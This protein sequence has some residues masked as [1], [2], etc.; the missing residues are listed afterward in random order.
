MSS[1]RPPMTAGSAALLAALTILGFLGNYYSVPLFFGA[2]F[3]FGSIAVLL[4]LYFYGLTYGLIVAIIVNIYCFFLWGHPYGSLNFILEA[5][6]VGYLLRSGHKNLFLID[7]AFWLFVGV[8]LVVLEHTVVL[9]MGT[10]ITIFIILKQAI[11]GMFNAL[12]ANLCIAYLPLDKFLGHAPTRRTFSLHETLFNLLAALVLLPALMLTIIEIRHE[13]QEIEENVQAQL[14]GV[15]ADVLSHLNSWYFRHLHAV[16]ELALMAAQSSMTPSTE[17]QQNIAVLRQ[18]FPDFAA[19]HVENAQ[20]TA[21]AFARMPQEKPGF[22]IGLNFADRT[23]FKEA[24]AQ[25]RPFLSDIFVGNRAVFSPIVGIVVPILKE[26]EFLGTATGS[27]NLNR[28]SGVLEPYG[29]YWGVNLT[30]TDSYGHIIASTVPAR[31]PLDRLDSLKIEASQINQAAIYHRFP[32]DAKLP[33][34]TRWQKSFYVQETR[35]NPEI[36]WTLVLEAPVSPLQKKLY[37]IYIQNLLIMTL[38]IVCVLLLAPP[39][40]RWLANPLEKLAKV[41]SDLPDQLKKHSAID[42]PKSSANEM[43]VL[44]N[45]FQSM[46]SILEQNFQA[47]ELRGEELARANEEL[48]REFEEREQVEKSLRESEQRFRDIAENASEWIWEVNA[49]GKYTYSNAVGEKLLG[50]PLEDILTKHFY[51][52]FHPDD[53]ESLKQA[54]FSVFAQK[55]SF[56][57]FINRNINARGETIWVLTSGVPLLDDHGNLLGYRGADRDITSRRQT[58]AALR[59]SEMKYRLMVENLPAVV[60]KGYPDWRTEFFDEKVEELTGYDKEEFNSGKVKWSDVIVQEDLQ[61]AKEA[62]RQA[63]NGNKLYAREYRITKKGGEIIWIQARGQ[64]VCD[65]S[66]RIDHVSGVFF[67]ITDRKKAEEEWIKLSKLESLGLLAGGI[68]HDFNNILMGI[69][70]NL[71]LCSRERGVSPEVQERLT[72]AEKACEQAR[73]L[74]RQLLT[75]A[76]GGAPIKEIIAIDRIINQSAMLACRGTQSRCEFHLASDLWAVEIDAGQ[77]NQVFQNLVINAV[78]AMPLGG[79]VKIYAGNAAIGEDSGLP[80]RPGN[81]VKIDFCDQGL[82]IPAEYLSKIFDPYFTTK[83]R[84][85]GLGLATSYSIVKNHNGHITVESTLEKGSIFTIYLPGLDLKVTPPPQDSEELMKR[86]GSILVMDD[87][88]IVQKVLQQMLVSLGYDVSFAWN[89]EEAIKTFAAAKAS[90]QNFDAVILDLT[91]PD[92]MG[93]KEAMEQLLALDPQVKGIVSSGYFDDS[94]MAEFKKYG[95]SGVICKPY[96]LTELAKTLSQ[97]IAGSEPDG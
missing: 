56:R 25:R 86:K 38:L 37:D 53:R 90:G 40:S 16:S 6:F 44:I 68:A 42:W 4:I 29:K 19:L 8:P 30:L 78:Q 75:F 84:G 66:G 28:L 18:A 32:P 13:M 31:R 97:V 47:L 48:R 23:W 7:G 27:V 5:L 95:F 63:L 65:Q 59:E 43:A 36:P 74:A 85:S 88:E 14:R 34:M 33:S 71:S 96:T 50:C 54:A 79:T 52:F 67:D 45:N 11:N 24:R 58:E 64:I 76:K 80:L 87:E 82:G 73:A 41:T 61:N 55:L 15:S 69:L 46:A 81:Y 17:L 70:G 39:L 60:F 12:M 94:V 22:G 20:G 62:F 92:G 35:M 10:T 51:D 83:Q 72:E 1:P 93:G 91:V 57:D 26:Q 21:I 89:G 3:L 49:E 2:D 9:Q 77:M